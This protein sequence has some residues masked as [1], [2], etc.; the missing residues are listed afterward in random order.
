MLVLWNTIYMDA[1]P[2]QLRNEGFA[3]KEEEDVAQSRA[4]MAACPF[5]P[6]LADALPAAELTRV[7]LGRLV[8]DLL[9]DFFPQQRVARTHPSQ[10]DNQSAA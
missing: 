4:A 7:A 6:I 1:I 9:L 3:V 10:L 2:T 8:D 5:G